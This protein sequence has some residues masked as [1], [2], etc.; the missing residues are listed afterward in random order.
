MSRHAR[1]RR[2]H[3]LYDD[4]T[5]LNATVAAMRH[6]LGKRNPEDLR[7]GSPEW[8]SANEDFVRDLYCILS[9]TPPGQT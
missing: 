5:T 1:V 8:E 4:V 2:G 7:Y 9:G 6:A 3:P